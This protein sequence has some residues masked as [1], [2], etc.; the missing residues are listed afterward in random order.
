LRS[1]DFELYFEYD[2]SK[3]TSEGI[4]R[5]IPLGQALSDSKLSTGE[6]LI[7]GHT[8]AAGSDAYNARLSRERA[9]SV[10]DFLVTSFSITPHRLITVGYGE[11]DLKT[12]DQPLSRFNRRVQIVNLLN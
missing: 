7:A 9:R 6:F 4:R 1:I 12:P 11:G 2:S 5:L 3:L 10:K 8:D